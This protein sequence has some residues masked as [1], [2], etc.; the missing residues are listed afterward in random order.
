MKSRKNTCSLL[1]TR[2]N[3]IELVCFLV[4]CWQR[5]NILIYD[6][7]EP[8]IRISKGVF[9]CRYARKA[10]LRRVTFFMN[11]MLKLKESIVFSRVL[12]AVQERRYLR[13]FRSM[14]K[15]SK[16]H[17]QIYPVL[18]AN[19]LV[20]GWLCGAGWAGWLD[21]LGWL[22]WLAGW[23]VVFPSEMYAF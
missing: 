20:T 12:L 22:A 13:H 16:K 19:G 18:L 23:M 4:F 9:F 14:A 11:L 15:M 2:Y 1:K 21:W 8:Y 5:S 17:L 3:C 10:P 7:S 6:G